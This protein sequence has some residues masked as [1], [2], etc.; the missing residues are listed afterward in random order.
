MTA[1]VPLL[2]AGVV[3]GT[4]SPVAL[5]WVALVGYG[6]YGV[7]FAMPYAVTVC[8]SGDVL[9]DRVVGG[10]RVQRADALQFVYIQTRNDEDRAATMIFETAMIKVPQLKNGFSGVVY[11]LQ[12]LNPHI[13]VERSPFP[14]A[15]PRRW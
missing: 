8:P 10:P 1:A 14:M 7:L 3:A 5:V 4:V 6:W 2:F 15:W 13:V 11:V 12:R 9:F